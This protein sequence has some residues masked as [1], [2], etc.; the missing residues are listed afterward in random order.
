LLCL[1][2]TTLVHDRGVESRGT[3]LHWAAKVLTTVKPIKKRKK[4][5]Y[6]NKKEK[7][8]RRKGERPMNQTT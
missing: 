5:K 2:T 8:Q 4:K 1:S 7:G 3:R 6:Y